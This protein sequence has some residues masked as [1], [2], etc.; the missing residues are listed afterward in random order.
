[1]NDETVA[2]G[3]ARGG[4]RYQ[5]LRGWLAAA[6]KLG[7]VRVVKGATW[8]EEIGSAA[9][10][11]QHSETAP[12][13]LFEDIPDSIPG[14][15]VLVNFFAAKRMNMTLGFPLEL[16]KL[17]LTN[18]FH[19]R[20][21]A[22]LDLVPYEVVEDGPVLE[23]VIEGDDVDITRFPAPQWH[24]ADGGRYIGTG[25]FNVT[26]DPDSG[27]I[28]LGTYRVMIHDE[29]SVGFYISPGKHGRI[30]RDKYEAQGEPMP[31]LVIAGGDPATFLM[32][33]SEIPPGICEY[34]VVGGLRGEPVNVVLG[35]HTGLPMPANAELVLEG[36]I[37]PGRRVLEGPFGEWTGYYAS[38]IRPEPVMDVK[39]VYYRND[40]ILLGCPPQR[41]PDELAR[42]RA[43]TRSAMLKE[44]IARAG[45]PDVTAAWAHEVG[46]A[47]MLLA[48]AIE[49][50]YAGHA[51][52]AGHIAAQCHVG[53]YAGKWVIVV[54]D[55]IDVSNLEEVIWAALTRSDPATS[56]DVITEAW[57]T[58]LDP[59]IPP[60]QKARGEF[61]NS[62]L[63]ID[64]CRPYRW[65]EEFPK[66]N[67]PD[68]ETAQAARRKWGYLLEG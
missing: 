16:T 41:P 13:V 27:W 11:V 23:N 55:D 48:V 52:Q 54:D 1:M 59:R 22:D 5:D 7:E 51:R 38:D 15:R 40:P 35:R 45:V 64:A 17:E 28:N 6:D 19:E 20:H 29:R 58:P 24:E 66:V 18:A 68:R 49:Q 3:P 12:A 47:R 31:A 67:A 8:Q 42:Y 62:R 44:N 53:A 14:S 26:R 32:A 36:F 37:E 61:T 60:E 2:A 33:C 63:I 21:M 9:E 10:V 30:H 39:A 56:L 4:I 25:S 50:R 65:R 34:D 43:V 46:T 57:S